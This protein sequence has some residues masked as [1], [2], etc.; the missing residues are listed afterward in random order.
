LKP[1]QVLNFNLI[2][3]G[4]F[5][6][7]FSKSIKLNFFK[8]ETTQKASFSNTRFRMNHWEFWHCDTCN[9]DL[10]PNS[11]Y[12]HLKSKSHLAKDNRVAPCGTQECGVCYDVGTVFKCSQCV[13]AWCA[14]CHL[15][16]DKCPFCRVDISKELKLK[17]S[18]Q[19]SRWNAKWV[20]ALPPYEDPN[21]WREVQEMEAWRALYRN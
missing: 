12:S 3:F 17:L 19:K 16:L 4:I 13:N 18:A 21:N 20:F 9:V 6:N 14:T 11:K 10:K 1:T 15:R 8:S 7:R 5:W 2:N